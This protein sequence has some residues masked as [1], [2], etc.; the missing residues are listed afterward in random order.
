MKDQIDK[1]AEA[2]EV[3]LASWEERPPQGGEGGAFVL[4]SVSVRQFD[5]RMDH[6]LV[7]LHRLGSEPGLLAVEELKLVPDKN[8]GRITGSMVITKLVA[9]PADKSAPAGGKGA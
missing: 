6:L 9:T 1:L 2:S 8:A 3:K 4:Q 5:A 7:F